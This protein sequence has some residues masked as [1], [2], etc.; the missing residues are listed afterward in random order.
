[1]CRLKQSIYFHF[2]RIKKKALNTFTFII[3]KSIAPNLEANIHM[4]SCRNLNTCIF[5]FLF[6]YSICV[7]LIVFL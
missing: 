1:M 2:D 7:N 6:T 4:Y 3:K 5:L